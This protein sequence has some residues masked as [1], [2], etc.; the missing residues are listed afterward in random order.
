MEEKKKSNK[1]LIVF[2]IIL[3]IIIIGLVGYI[4]VDKGIIKLTAEEVE[5]KNN[6]SE[7]KEEKEEPTEEEETSEVSEADAIK[8]YTDG[9][10][11]YLMLYPEQEIKTTGANG[12]YTSSVRTFYLYVNYGYGADYLT[13]TYEINENQITL[14]FP[15]SSNQIPLT[16]ILNMALQ[17]GQIELQTENETSYYITLPYT[18]NSITYANLTLTLQ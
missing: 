1:G 16:N 7:A 10:Y 13:G 4:A 15:Q 12:D 2:V 17:G 11:Y 14:R 9:T 18:E 5:E 3:I 6:K 8:C